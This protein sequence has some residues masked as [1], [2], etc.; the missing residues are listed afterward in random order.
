M[1]SPLDCSSVDVS[2]PLTSE[3]F[4]GPVDFQNRTLEVG[5][6]RRDASAASIINADQLGMAIHLDTALLWSA[7]DCCGKGMHGAEPTFNPS[8]SRDPS[9]FH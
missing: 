4:D 5:N 8:P 1:P 9:V 3:A 6:V 2:D 7:F